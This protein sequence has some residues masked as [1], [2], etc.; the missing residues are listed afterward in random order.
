MGGNYEKDMYKQLCQLMSRVDSL[1]SDHKKDRKEIKRLNKELDKADRRIEYLNKTV[2][3]QVEEITTLKSENTALKKEN[4][5][6]HADNERMRRILNNNSDNSSLP[7]ST[8]KN[9]PGKAA[10][11][12]NSRN[13]TNRKPGAQT[14]STGTTLTKNTVKS[15]IDEGKIENTVIKEIGTPGPDYISRFVLDFSINTIAKEIRIYPDGNGKYHVPDEYRSEVTYGDG[16][17]AIVSM[18]YSDGIVSND[19]IAD[20]INGLSGDVLKLS[21]GTVYH[22]CQ[23]FG[24]ICREQKPVIEND[25]LCSDVLCTDATTMCLDGKQK[26][27]R[28][29]S[30]LKSVLYT[31]QEKKKLK[32][33]S[34]LPILPDFAGIL[35]HDH[36]TAMYHFGTGHGECCVHLIRYLRKN[37][38]ESQNTWSKDLMNF[39]AGMNTA[40]KKLIEQGGSSFDED[41]L[42][43]Y[44]ARYDEL[45]ELGYQQNKK[46][47]NRL[48]K[49]EEKTLLNR[50]AKYKVNHLL[51]LKDF[52]VPFDDNMSERDLRMCK[53]R[54]K[55]SG[56]F[57]KE[58]GIQMFCDIMSVIRTIKRRGMNIFQSI[59]D[60]FAGRPVIV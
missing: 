60:L 44:F 36:E 49:K 34:T 16:I 33:L 31:Y 50:L 11:E 7:P 24:A 5:I 8:D 56:G 30:N 48:A 58:S 39:L 28:N 10:N 47:S 26:Y 27:I 14:G 6:L 40:R 23:Q 37:T 53:Q 35:I 1:E 13:K 55:M 42:K 59:K 32:V 21:T 15:L 17:R 57:R 25:L 12:Y 22:I 38:E 19:R 54:Q 43:K 4:R 18:L 52:R 2:T 51:F 3:K 45:V 9:N 20:F 29:F 46:T 41:A